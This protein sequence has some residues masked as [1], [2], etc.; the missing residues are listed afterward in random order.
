MTFEDDRRNLKYEEPNFDV[1]SLDNYN[2]EFLI[3]IAS[4]QSKY[5]E[6]LEKELDL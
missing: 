4:W 1:N 6:L 3:K 2:N 5:I